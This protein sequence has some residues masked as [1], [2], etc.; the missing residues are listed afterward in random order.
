MRKYWGKIL[1]KWKDLVSLPGVS[2]YIAGTILSFGVERK[3][4]YLT[5]TS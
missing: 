1:D 3:L 4:Q 2:V 5:P